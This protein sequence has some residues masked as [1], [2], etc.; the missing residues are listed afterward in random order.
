MGF[1][2]ADGYIQQERQLGITLSRKD[3]NQL[4]KFSQ[5]IGL[6]PIQK[7]VDFERE[8]NE[9]I[10]E[11]SRV[12]FGCKPLVNDLLALDYKWVPDYIKNSVDASRDSNDLSWLFGLY[13]GDG[14]QGKISIYSTRREVLEQI[15][16]SFN[17]PNKVRKAK[18]PRIRVDVN[19]YPKFDSEGSPMLT[20]TLYV[21]RLGPS[22][23]NKMMDNYQDSLPRKRK[24][25]DERIDATER[26]KELFD[27]NK[28][29]LQELISSL[30]RTQILTVLRN[31]F[32]IS[33]TA[34]KNLIKQWDIDIPSPGY[35]NTREGKDK[36][37][38][39]Q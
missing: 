5:E 2:S 23:F 19:G 4:V 33:Y 9:K 21:L 13:D 1:L 35:W 3:R 8:I 38:I 34:L 14:Q 39:P 24:Y 37:Q 36:R 30:P 29:L 27:N 28:D 16:N 26:L 11:L 7:V 25:F 18:N 31:S 17:V 20:K 22:L 32:G 10:Y 12:T 15:S 6:D